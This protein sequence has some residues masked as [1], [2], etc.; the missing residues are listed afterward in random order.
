MIRVL[1][2]FCDSAAIYFR[3]KD[4]ETYI[5]WE[6]ML[7]IS[8]ARALV[9]ILTILRGKNEEHLECICKEQWLF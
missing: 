4:F 8:L 5:V 2:T 1:Y 9:Q 7:N 6:E 3:I